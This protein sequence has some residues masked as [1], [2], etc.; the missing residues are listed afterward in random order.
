MT[1]FELL[2]PLWHAIA[3][4][5]TMWPLLIPIAGVGLCVAWF[6]VVTEELVRVALE[7]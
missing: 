2:N 4:V 5:L 6:Y 7:D 1:F 3:R